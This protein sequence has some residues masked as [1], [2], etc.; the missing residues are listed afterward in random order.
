[1]SDK[2]T[3]AATQRHV[4]A[5]HDHARGKRRLF[6]QICGQFWGGELVAELLTTRC[7]AGN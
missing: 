4:W 5:S 7:T 2:E 1:M 6:I 3:A